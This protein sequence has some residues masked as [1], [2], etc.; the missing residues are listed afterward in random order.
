MQRLRLEA[1]AAAAPNPPAGPLPGGPDGDGG[2][3]GAW[4][5]GFALAIV[6]YYTYWLCAMNWLKQG[7]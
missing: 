5:H 3:G 6:A 1:E 4:L 7:G 2:D